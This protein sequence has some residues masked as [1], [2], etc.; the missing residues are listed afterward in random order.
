MNESEQ[1]M[2]CRKAIKLTSKPSRV[3]DSGQ[4]QTAPVYGL[5]GVRCRGCMILIQALMWNVGTYWFNV[6]GR[7]VMKLSYFASTNVNQRGGAT[8]SSD[9]ATVMGVEQ[10][11]CVIWSNLAVNQIMGGAVNFGKVI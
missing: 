1:S 10:R 7:E 4:I 8:R 9:E 6:K 3:I 5:G 11:G 2:T